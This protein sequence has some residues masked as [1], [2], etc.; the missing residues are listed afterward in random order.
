MTAIRVDPEVYA[1]ASAVFGT[2]LAGLVGDA[3]SRLESDL[4]GMSRIAGSDPAGGE[5]A[6]SYDRIAGQG[7]H[8]PF[9]IEVAP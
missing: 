7:L 2:T 5:W 4:A 8:F 6:G 3:S 9:T 1:A